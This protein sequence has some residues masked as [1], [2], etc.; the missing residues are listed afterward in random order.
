MP[1]TTTAAPLGADAGADVV[2]VG[3]GPAGSSA[4]WWLAQAGL[5]VVVLEKAAF[6]V[7]RC[8]ATA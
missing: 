3:A 2:V 4:A 5:D 1:G 7:R 8:A 6:P